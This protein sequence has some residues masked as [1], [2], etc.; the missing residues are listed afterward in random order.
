[1]GGNTF[2]ALGL[3]F[4]TMALTLVGPWSSR[5]PFKTLLTD[6]AFQITIQ[7]QTCPSPAE[8]QAPPQAMNGAIFCKLGGVGKTSKHYGVGHG[9][10]PC[11]SLFLIYFAINH[12]L[13]PSPS[14]E[15]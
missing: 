12:Y 13:L 14:F 5:H 3:V 4:F 9:S 1:M 11:W 8:G 2:K 6:S 15:V 7:E 10:V